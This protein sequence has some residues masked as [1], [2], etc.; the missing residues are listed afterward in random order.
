[1]D[2]FVPNK[3]LWIPDN[4]IADSLVSPIG[5]NRM[6]KWNRSR[7]I[8]HLTP[9]RAMMGAAGAGAGGG[10]VTSYKLDGT[11][12]YLSIPDDASFTLSGNWTIEF[13]LY[14]VDFSLSA[15]EYVYSQYE[16][17]S[18][19]IEF[20]LSAT[21]DLIAVFRIGGS[22]TN[23]LSKTNVLTDAAWNHVALV[24]S[25][26]SNFIFIAGVDQTLS[27]S[28]GSTALPNYAAEIQLGAQN[29]ISGSFLLGQMDE[30]R[31]SNI[32]R[33]T[34]G[35]TVETSEFASDGNTVLLI[36]CGETKT[37]TTGSGATFT[38]SGNIGHIV[39]ENGNAIEDGVL[40]KF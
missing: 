6:L 27:S 16:D 11:G 30:Y 15:D 31:V 40:F 7:R 18:N 33:Y 19:R 29:A 17:A 39:T 32:A 8:C 26:S 1:M 24:H 20:K 4:T 35:F 34:S 21:D 12:D 14:V 28:H 5:I 22:T 9:H 38:D 37:G 23:V 2:I 13:W 25:G 10:D 3:K 36:H